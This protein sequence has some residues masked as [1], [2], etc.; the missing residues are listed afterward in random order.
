MR[1]G[2]AGLPQRS[3]Q[4]AGAQSPFAAA[5]G[6]QLPPAHVGGGEGQASG[7]A[8]Q[9][10]AADDAGDV[11]GHAAAPL[12][13]D[14]VGGEPRRVERV[15]AGGGDGACVEQVSACSEAA[16]AGQEPPGS[17]T[18]KIWAMR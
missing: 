3:R 14:L 2:L 6:P 12:G 13:L 16:A 4:R 11:G 17:T 18:A 10:R 9:L 5:V 15:V 1:R 7:A 8:E